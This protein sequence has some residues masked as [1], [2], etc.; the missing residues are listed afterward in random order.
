[1]SSEHF[2]SFGGARHPASA[3]PS[4]PKHG[5]RES[6]LQ[7]SG[8]TARTHSRRAFSWEVVAESLPG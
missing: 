8:K 5:F 7:L 6:M 3:T 4:L 1:M 2:H